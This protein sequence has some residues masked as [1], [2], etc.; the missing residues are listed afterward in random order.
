[1]QIRFGWSRIF[2]PSLKTNSLFASDVNLAIHPDAH[3]ILAPN[4]GSYVGGDI[5]AGALVSMI[6]NR[7]EMSLFIDLG[8]NG[9]LAFGNSDFMVSCACSAGPAFEGGDISCGMRATDGAIEKCTI[10]PETM[11]PSYHVIG[12]EGTKPIG[13]CGS[14]IIDVIAALFRAKMVNPKGKF[15]REGRTDP[16]RQIWHGKLC[17]CVRGGGWKCPRC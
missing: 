13:L 7:P 11:E 14:G 9:E 1:M 16:P 17:H 15:I 4:I 12:D 2:R 6:W 10:D 8:T 5:T 3:I